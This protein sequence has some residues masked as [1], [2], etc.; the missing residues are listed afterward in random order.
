MTYFSGSF[1]HP[2]E[3]QVR[4]PAE[5]PLLATALILVLALALNAA[6]GNR[7]WFW[8]TLVGLALLGLFAGSVKHLG[9]RLP[10]RPTWAVGLAGSLHYVGGSLSA[11]GAIGGVNGLY[12]VLP[13]WDNLTH[14]LGS[15][16]VGVAAYAI[17]VH[18]HP[19]LAG[20]AGGVLAVGVAQLV[21]VLIELYELVGFLFFGTVDQGFYLNNAIDLYYNV[22]GAAVA[23]TGYALYLARR[24]DPAT[25]DESDPIGG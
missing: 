19:S 2:M 18:Y 9:L 17:L 15:G 5:A 24:E 21:G 20:L 13:W 12:Y 16:A 14:F 3:D 4:S 8:Y 10:R 6:T 25:G 1:R 11:V 7:L 22:L 23:V